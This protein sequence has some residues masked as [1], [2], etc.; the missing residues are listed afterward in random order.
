MCVKLF[1]LTKLKPHVVDKLAAVGI[2][3]LC[4]EPLEL[5]LEGLDDGE[6]VVGVDVDGDLPGGPSPERELETDGGG[7]DR[8]L[9]PR[10]V[11]AGHSAVILEQ[12][13]F[14]VGGG[15]GARVGVDVLGLLYRESKRKNVKLAIRGEKIQK[16][17]RKHKLITLIKKL[18]LGWA[19]DFDLVFWAGDERR[20]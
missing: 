17:H 20:G 16:Q 18:T 5:V 11:E 6:G 3:V 4:L 14:A 13:Y 2:V 8:G 9:R 7:G 15:V 12:L 10:H 1:L 19:L